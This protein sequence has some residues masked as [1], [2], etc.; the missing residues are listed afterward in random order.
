MV[1]S[2]LVGHS[3]SACV[4]VPG[5][6]NIFMF[7]QMGGKEHGPFK[8]GNGAQF[9]ASMLG[10]SQLPLAPV[11]GVGHPLPSSTGTYTHVHIPTYIH[12]YT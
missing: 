5:S 3:T 10:G 7:Y 6:A 11:P 2:C 12:T 1:H 9:P 8:Q 4:S